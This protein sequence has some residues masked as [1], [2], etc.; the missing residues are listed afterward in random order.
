MA[1]K[2]KKLLQ[3]INGKHLLICPWGSTIRDFRG[4][5]PYSEDSSGV[6]AQYDPKTFELRSFGSALN[7]TK[8]LQEKRLHNDGK[9]HV[10]FSWDHVDQVIKSEEDEES[11]AFKE[12]CNALVLN[13]QIGSDADMERKKFAIIRAMEGVI[14]KTKAGSMEES[15]VRWMKFFEW[16]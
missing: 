10:L 14:A 2:A 12:A 7:L 3:V 8:S 16:V 13:A 4:V 15:Y 6:Y 5:E 11:Y 1:K 9:F